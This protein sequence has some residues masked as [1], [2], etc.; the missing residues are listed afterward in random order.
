[1]EEIVNF[2]A[3][4]FPADGEIVPAYFE[5]LN[6]DALTPRSFSFNGSTDD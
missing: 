6:T 2:E 4:L 5:S 1:M 3:I